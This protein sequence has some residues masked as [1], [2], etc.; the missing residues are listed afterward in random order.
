MIKGY[1]S[2]SEENKNLYDRFL[3]NFLN[4]WGLRARAEIEVK[5]VYWC[6]ETTR[7]IKTVDGYSRIG[8]EYEKIVNGAWKRISKQQELK[9]EYKRNMID[10]KIYA[11]KKEYLRFDYFHGTSEYWLHVYGAND[12][13]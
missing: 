2:L 9:K 6:R 10:N 1:K 13:Y 11:R 8:E 7:F 4:G 12:Y 5:E 3:V